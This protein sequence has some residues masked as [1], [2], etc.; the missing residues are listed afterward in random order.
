MRLLMMHV[1]FVKNWGQSCYSCQPFLEV[2]VCAYEKQLMCSL[3][4]HEQGSQMKQLK[5][6]FEVLK[7]LDVS[8]TNVLYGYCVYRRYVCMLTQ[9]GVED[10]WC[11]VTPAL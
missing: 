8:F 9:D 5:S 7:T 10:D 3:V 1:P 4:L 2:L 6:C 11:W